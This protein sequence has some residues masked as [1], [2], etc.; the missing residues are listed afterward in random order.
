MTEEMLFLSVKDE[1]MQNREHEFLPLTH[2]Y[3]SSYLQ[4]GKR[5][6]SQKEFKRLLRQ[7]LHKRGPKIEKMIN[8]YLMLGTIIEDGENYIISKAEDKFVKLTI[9]TAQFCIENL[10]E[11]SMK[12]YCYLL[13]KKQIHDRYNYKENYFFSKSE[14][15]RAVGYSRGGKTELKLEQALA[16]LENL[17]LIEYNHQ[18]VGRPGVH[19]L[20]LELYN[21]NQYSNV[22]KEAAKN[23]I[24]E[25]KTI[26]DPYVAQQVCIPGVD[27]RKV[28]LAGEAKT[29]LEM[30]AYTLDCLPQKYLDAYKEV[31]N[32][33][34]N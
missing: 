20:Y 15:L 18:S 27:L 21:V 1:K 9:S 34:S 24:G 26:S 32:E 19:G 29:W 5:V 17:G 11:L 12:V 7:T 14:L 4:D 30:G 33:D 23:F 3:F 8:A 28:Q 25:G 13:N 16:L 10:S 22:Q 31:Y 6:I 2:A